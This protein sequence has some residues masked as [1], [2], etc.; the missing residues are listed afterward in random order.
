MTISDKVDA[1]AGDYML[2]GGANISFRTR[3]MFGLGPVKGRLTVQSGII[4]VVQGIKGS[5]VTAL[6]DAK[7]FTTRN[8]LR[9]VQV[10][11]PLFLGVKRNPTFKFESTDVVQKGSDWVVL[12]TLTV[13][14]KT[15]P[16]SVVL[17]R[18]SVKDGML[19]IHARGEVDRYAL[20]VK[21]MKGMAARKLT[22][23]IDSFATAA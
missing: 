8:P 19:H 7:S 16:V 23:E 20:G 3:H 9:D 22:F 13:R 1:P 18:L 2:T 6:I 14:G 4:D 10:R 17:D 15:A 11:S 5:T 21:M 12:G